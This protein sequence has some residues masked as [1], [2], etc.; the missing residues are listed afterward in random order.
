MP[1]EPKDFPVFA[2]DFIEL[3]AVFV[4]MGIVFLMLVLLGNW[5]ER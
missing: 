4:M 3:L 5:W 2:P 1:L